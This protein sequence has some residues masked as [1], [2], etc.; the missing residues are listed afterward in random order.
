VKITVTLIGGTLIV[1]F[2]LILFTFQEISIF[3][4]P[5]ALSA[6]RSREFCSCLFVMKRDEVYCEK[7][8]TRAMPSFDYQ[9]DQKKKEVRFGPSGRFVSKFISK[10]EGCRLRTTSLSD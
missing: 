5:T 1:L 4:L 9:L 2:L 3:E 6:Y 7:M 10:K 8:V